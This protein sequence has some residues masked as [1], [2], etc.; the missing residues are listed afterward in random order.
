MSRKFVLLALAVV[1]LVLISGGITLV[2]MLRH[3][4]HFY[5]RAALPADE[6]RKRRSREFYGGCS[7]LLNGVLSYKTWGAS[8]TEAQLNSYFAEGFLRPG[9]IERTFFPDA[10]QHPR[11]AIDTDHIRLGMRCG[12]GWWSTIVSVDL[13]VWLVAAEPNVVAVEIERTRAG[14]VPISAQSMLEHLSEAARRQ[15]IEVTWYRREGK[16]VALLRFGAGRRETSI[17]LL[18]L[19]FQ[20]GVMSIHGAD[21]AKPGGDADAAPVSAAPAAH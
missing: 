16:P 21:R 2:L 12:S 18:Q 7:Q 13:R 9:N 17:Q 20:P 14:A 3:E 8:F 6:L 1:V 10:A 15:D 5:R 11:A 19:T 4:P